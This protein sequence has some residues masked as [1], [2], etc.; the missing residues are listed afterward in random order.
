MTHAP[1]PRRRGFGLL[2][3]MMGLA[4]IG[5][6]LLT[7]G[8]AVGHFRAGSRTLADQRAAVRSAEAALTAMQAGRPLP[9]GAADAQIEALPAEGGTAP[10]GQRWVEV[11]ARVHGQQAAVTGLVP[12]TAEEVRP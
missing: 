3:V 4:V 8:A 11:R 2:D 6:L 1:T 5:I 9:R 12:A 10:A 7:L